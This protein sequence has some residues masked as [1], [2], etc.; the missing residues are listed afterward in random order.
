MSGSR[1]PVLLVN[2]SSRL[3]NYGVLNDLSAIEPPLWCALLAGWIR[4]SREMGV[5]I[6]D[7]E[8][9][10]LTVHQTAKSVIAVNPLL[11]VIVAMGLNPSVSSTPKMDAVGALV[12]SIRLEMA[13]AGRRDIKIMVAGLHPSALPEQT[14]RETQADYVCQGEGFYT[15]MN[16]AAA[17]KAGEDPSDIPGLWTWWGEEEF[18]TPQR[19][20]PS[21]CLGGNLIP[22]PAWDLLPMTRYRAHNWH[23]LGHLDKR[24]PY[25]VVATSLGCP[26]NCSYCNVHTMYG[27]ER[28]IRRRPPYDVLLELEMM[29]A[30]GIRNIKLWDEMFAIHESSVVALCNE[31]ARK[32]WGLNIW[33]Y[34]RANTVTQ[35]MLEAMKKAGV[36]WVC[37]GFESADPLVREGVC[38]T[39]TSFDFSNAV[40]WTKE[41]G[42]NIIANYLLG[43]PDDTLE[44]MQAT[45]DQAQEANFEWLNVYCAAP[46]PGSQL[47][48]DTPA[49]ARPK[50]WSDYGQFAPGFRPLP[51]KTLPGSE[52]LAFRDRAFK[53]Y[54]NRPAYL[55]MIAAKFG[56][57]AR[58][59]VLE[60][61]KTEVKRNERS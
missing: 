37:Y 30:Y 50:R 13:D 43:L 21:P 9:G 4:K 22:M 8:M 26:F 39:T 60:M 47:Y 25:G 55:D 57:E 15:V 58:A 44:T 35:K 14:M 48:E 19:P 53:E 61:L 36:N 54:F 7:A 52:V 10:N 38:K 34:G 2:P 12:R 56:V 18:R 28:V 46:M 16:T 31:I 17:L 3:E 20:H 23:C 5:E 32:G 42:I 59:H 41:A 1:L 49:T 27:G 24:R 6:M 45:M 40:R 33:A 29:V 51:T 11:V